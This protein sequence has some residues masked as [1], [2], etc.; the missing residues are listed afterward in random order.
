MGQSPYALL[1]PVVAELT[2]RQSRISSILTRHSNPLMTAVPRR[3]APIPMP[4]PDRERER[5]RKIE[6]EGETQEDSY[7]PPPWV[8]RVEY[9]T[10][11]GQLA[12]AFTQHDMMRD[13]LAAISGVPESLYGIL[14]GGQQPS[15]ASLR[16]QHVASYLLLESYE[17]ALIPILQQI[18]AAA[19]AG[20]DVEIT[21]LNP[22]DELDAADIREELVQEA[23]NLD[24][25]LTATTEERDIRTGQNL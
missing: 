17:H 21:W 19:G 1:V 7:V 16:R 11:D 13:A 12:A 5:L 24:E 18:I 20:D 8:E 10:W 3:D 4:S 25:A 2:R 15:G 9:V 23:D 22:L 6:F 14:R